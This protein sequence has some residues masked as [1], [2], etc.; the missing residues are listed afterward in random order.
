MIDVIVTQLCKTMTFNCERDY[1]IKAQ[2]SDD[3]LPFYEPG[4][5]TA[6]SENSIQIVDVITQS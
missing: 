4:K 2:L 1:L 3:C 6:L 5:Q